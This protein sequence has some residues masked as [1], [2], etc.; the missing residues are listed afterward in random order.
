LLGARVD[1]ARN[2]DRLA[3]DQIERL[4][5]EAGPANL[6][7]QSHQDRRP[8]RRSSR[9]MV[10]L[11]DNRWLSTWRATRSS[12]PTSGL[13]SAYRASVPSL[14]NVTKW[15]ARRAA[16]CCDMAG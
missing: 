14:R 8:S 2:G 9:S 12:S 16:R 7:K 1:V 10:W 13:R 11:S 3:G 4:G 5:D 15:R 6:A